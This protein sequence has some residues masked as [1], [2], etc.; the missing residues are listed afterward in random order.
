[1]SLRSSL[2]P[3]ISCLFLV[4]FATTSACL[5]G[6][7]CGFVSRG[8]LHGSSVPILRRWLYSLCAF[9]LRRFAPN[10][11]YDRGKGRRKGTRSR[12][13]NQKEKH[14]RGFGRARS[15]IS[16]PMECVRM[17]FCARRNHDVPGAA[18]GQLRRPMV[19]ANVSI[20]SSWQVLRRH[21]RQIRQEGHRMEEFTASSQGHGH[22]LCS[23]LQCATLFSGSTE[24]SHTE[25]RTTYDADRPS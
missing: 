20:L 4:S 14:Q 16:G 11:L 2:C 7:T 18:N 25:P 1:M 23:A 13:K 8:C 9:R 6:K 19:T 10:G 22:F 17:R 24:S 21:R 15:A 12:K 5:H 3:S